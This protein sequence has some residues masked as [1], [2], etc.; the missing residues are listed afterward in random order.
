MRECV[1]KVWADLVGFNFATSSFNNGHDM[2][3]LNPATIKPA[4]NSWLS[5]PTSP[6]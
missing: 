6:C 3:S 2:I 1:W 5:N 4:K